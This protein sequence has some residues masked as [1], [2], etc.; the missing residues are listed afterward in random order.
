VSFASVDDT[1]A[2]SIAA[3]EVAVVVGSTHVVHG[4]PHDKA[5][6]GWMV[7]GDEYHTIV[8]F[9]FHSA[10]TQVRIKRQA[11]LSNVA[12]SLCS[13][14]T[15]GYSRWWPSHVQGRLWGLV[16]AEELRSRGI[17]RTA[18]VRHCFAHSHRNTVCWLLLFLAIEDHE[19]GNTTLCV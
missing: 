7:S 3:D 8:A 19:A 1:V 11:I 10:F 6:S 12:L 4:A 2:G 9:A 18:T 17:P 16:L 15:I 13:S 14:S 5:E